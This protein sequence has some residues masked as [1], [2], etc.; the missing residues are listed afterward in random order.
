MGKPGDFIIVRTAHSRSKHKSPPPPG[1]LRWRG[2]TVALVGSLVLSLVCLSLMSTLVQ[3]VQLMVPQPA[4]PAEQKA[5]LAARSAWQA[6]SRINNPMAQLHVLRQGDPTPA[7]LS[8]WAT[9]DDNA[10]A[11]W[12]ELLV[13]LRAAGVTPASATST[14]PVSMDVAGLNDNVITSLLGRLEYAP[15]VRIGIGRLHATFIGT[16]RDSGISARRAEGLFFADRWSNL[17]AVYRPVLREIS[18]RMLASGRYYQ[19]SGRPE[20]AARVYRLTARLWADVVA[21]SPLPEVALLAAD[22]LEPI[23]NAMSTLGPDGPDVRPAVD[24][25]AAFRRACVDVPQR[26][27]A[28]L[29]A[30]LSPAI[31][32]AAHARVLGSLTAGATLLAFGWVLAVICL[33]LLAVV[34]FTRA[35]GA[36]P[37][38]WRWGGWGA[39]IAPAMVIVPFVGVALVIASDVVPFVWLASKPSLGVVLFAPGS[40]ILHWM[41]ASRLSLTPTGRYE[42]AALS[43]RAVVVGL[44]AVA[45]LA[46]LTTLLVSMGGSSWHPPMSVRLLRG[47][48]TVAGLSAAVVAFVW[49]LLGA[50]RRRQA[51]L[52]AGVWA[53]GGLAVAGAAMCAML[54]AAAIALAVNQHRDRAHETAFARAVNDPLAARLGPDWYTTSFEPVR[55]LAT[56]ER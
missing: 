40:L 27:L 49:A 15:P 16:L 13:H 20:Q 48:G 39:V 45:A 36:V 34:V 46:S 23:L 17:V 42:N 10:L 37:L 31:T 54:L 47:T 21:D 4:R 9:G 14:Q 43:P 2:T 35:Y 7:Q 26:D 25:L 6:D 22:Q 12:A 52:P 41:L 1:A 50:R 28:V 24:A 33:M 11:I 30:S 19:H 3:Q 44:A 29:P 8:Q 32:G 5:V 53:R 51:G 38:T 18:G 55:Q 56:Q